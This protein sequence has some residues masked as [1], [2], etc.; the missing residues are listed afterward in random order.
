MVSYAYLKLGTARL[1]MTGCNSKSSS[2]T[3]NRSRRAIST[4]YRMKHWKQLLSCAKVRILSM[5]QP[6]MRR[7]SSYNMATNTKNHHRSI[8][9]SKRRLRCPSS[10]RFVGGMTIRK[11]W[12]PRMNIRWIQARKNRL[13]Q[14]ILQPHLEVSATPLSKTN[15]NHTIVLKVQP[16]SPN[17]NQKRSTKRTRSRPKKWTRWRILN[18]EWKRR[19]QKRMR[20]L[21]SCQAK[22]SLNTL[23]TTM[24]R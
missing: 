17:P 8:K 23:R 5:H 21:R 9:S 18:K 11:R 2:I 19:W 12:C 3:C 13:E 14:D 20:P 7:N 15:W 4:S 10:S 16:K 1:M 22:H 24:I 6:T